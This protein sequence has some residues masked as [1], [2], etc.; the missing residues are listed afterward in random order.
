[1]RLFPETYYSSQKVRGEAFYHWGLHKETFDSLCLLI[2]LIYTKHK[3]ERW[4]LGL[5]LRPHFTSPKLCKRF[6]TPHPSTRVASSPIT[7]KPTTIG[8]TICKYSTCTKLRHLHRD[9][10]EGKLSNHWG[11]KRKSCTHLSF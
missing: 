2:L 9:R 8:L 1:M 11:N 6:Q 10:S 7:Q 3:T 4:N 5:I